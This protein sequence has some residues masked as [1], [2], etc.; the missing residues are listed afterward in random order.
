MDSSGSGLHHF[1]IGGCSEQENDRTG[2]GLLSGYLADS[3]GR[4]LL[5]AVAVLRTNSVQ[6][7]IPV[8]KA[9]Q[10][11]KCGRMSSHHL[12]R[13]RRKAE[14]LL[15]NGSSW[16][17]RL[18][19]TTPFSTSFVGKITTG[20]DFDVVIDQALMREERL[21]QQDGLC[22]QDEE[23]FNQ[24]LRTT[25]TNLYDKDS[26]LSEDDRDQS[27][28]DEMHQEEAEFSALVNIVSGLLKE[29]HEVQEVYKKSYAVYRSSYTNVP[30]HT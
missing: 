19:S 24:I 12:R 4:S 1:A 6:V 5:P 30:D 27:D 7:K 20:D 3:E 10:K 15:Y 28:V 16:I 21:Q 18:Y 13:R 23:K 11:S 8:S 29:S 25:A 9:S 26:V 22:L 14:L 17:Q 2:G